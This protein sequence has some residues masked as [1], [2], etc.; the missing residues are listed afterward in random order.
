M[1]G[2]ELDKTC[3]IIHSFFAR[4]VASSRIKDPSGF[5]PSEAVCLLVDPSLE[6]D[7]I[8]IKAFIDGPVG[9]D[10]VFGSVFQP[11]G[12][13]LDF[14]REMMSGRMFYW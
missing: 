3:A 8:P 2:T 13:N 7:F 11:V 12:V 10:E 1:T 6:Q 9:I 14:E 5:G 4:E